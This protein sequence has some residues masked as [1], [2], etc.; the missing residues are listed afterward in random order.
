[1]PAPRVKSVEPMVCLAYFSQ[2]IVK[3]VARYF[4]ATNTLSL[5][6][7]I[8]AAEMIIEDYP[9]M[10]VS[11]LKLCI[12]LA[13]KGRLGPDAKVYNVLDPAKIYDFVREYYKLSREQHIGITQHMDK[14]KRMIAMAGT[15]GELEDIK[16]RYERSKYVHPL[17]DRMIDEKFGML[18]ELTTMTVEEFAEVQKKIRQSENKLYTFYSARRSGKTE[19]IKRREAQNAIHLEIQKNLLQKMNDDSNNS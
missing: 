9:E 17:I 15:K 2:V 19:A 14:L 6:Q 16:A 1:M 8:G 11:E 4:N 18:E 13:A 12:T 3:Y 10:K 7:A 5:E